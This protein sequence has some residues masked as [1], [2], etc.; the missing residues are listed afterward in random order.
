MI[1]DANWLT[2]SMSP[3]H[4]DYH[5]RLI[6]TEGVADLVGARPSVVTTTH[7]GPHEVTLGR[8]LS[9]RRDDL[10]CSDVRSDPDNGRA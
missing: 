3:V 1:L 5:M 6:G 9:A 2:P 7:E 10:R 4:G 8:G